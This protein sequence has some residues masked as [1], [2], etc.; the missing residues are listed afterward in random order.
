MKA[1][2]I[3]GVFLVAFV[4][5]LA[6]CYSMKVHAVKSDEIAIAKDDKILVYVDSPNLK[7]QDTLATNIKDEFSNTA[8]KLYASMTFSPR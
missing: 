6:S 3:A 2:T 7:L 4:L 5:A 1:K 8:G